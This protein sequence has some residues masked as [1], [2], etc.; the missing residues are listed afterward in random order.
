[1]QQIAFRIAEE[2][3]LV[4][5][6][7]V[8]TTAGPNRVPFVGLKMLPEIVYYLVGGYQALFN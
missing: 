6:D 7:D 2:M 8:V 1:M 3:E 4:D 5:E